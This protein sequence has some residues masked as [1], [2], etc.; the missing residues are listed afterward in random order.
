[1]MIL[2]VIREFEV[3]KQFVDQKDIEEWIVAARERMLASSTLMA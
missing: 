2:E 1:M 3:A